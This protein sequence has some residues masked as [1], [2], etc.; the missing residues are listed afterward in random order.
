[1]LPKIIWPSE[2]RNI[3]EAQ[4]RRVDQMENSPITKGKGKSKTLIQTIK[5][6]KYNGLSPFF[7]LVCYYFYL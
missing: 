4:I 6:V 7:L 1:M 2:I 5:S 3:E